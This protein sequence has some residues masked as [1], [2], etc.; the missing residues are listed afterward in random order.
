[1]DQLKVS[2]LHL[3]LYGMFRKKIDGGNIIRLR[4]MTPIMKWC[5]RIPKR[6]HPEIIKEMIQMNLLKRNNRDHYELLFCS[7]KPLIDSLGNPLW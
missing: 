4:E 2:V 7:K 3:Y 5:M 6:Y 1:M